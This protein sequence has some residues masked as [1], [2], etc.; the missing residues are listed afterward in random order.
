MKKDKYLE[1]LEK[2]HLEL[3]Q[4]QQW[5]Q[6]QG[7]RV[8][9]L[10]EGRDAAG[11]GGIIKTIT[12]HL[13]PRHVKV[14]ALG[15]PTERETSQWYFQRYVA[16]LPAAGEIALFDRSW[17]NRAG[18]E[19][20]MGFCSHEQYEAFLAACPQF[21]KLLV[22]DG[23]ILIKYW[24][25]VSPEEQERR[26][27]SRLDDPLK[28]WKFSEM[29]LKGRERWQEYAKARD[30]LLDVTD[31]P[32]CPWFIVEA[33]DKKKARLNCISHLLSQIPYHRTQ[34]PKVH[35]EDVRGKELPPGKERSW[36]PERY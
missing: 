1:A 34:Y 10:F 16:H 24:L 8:V 12:E 6:R 2:L 28:R 14:V 22:D 23:I 21:E 32:H 15:V 26:F 11:K 3:V 9:V 36:V 5:V 35:L 17:Y 25:N 27:Q 33:N 18:V 4:L 30:R 31:H 7:L 20:V 19:K 29:D 13:N